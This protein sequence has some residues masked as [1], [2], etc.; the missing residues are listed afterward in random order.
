MKQM[1]WRFPPRGVFKF[2][3]MGVKISILILGRSLQSFF[4]KNDF[5]FKFL[6][7]LF[8]AIKISSDGNFMGLGTK[9]RPL[10]KRLMSLLLR[11]MEDKLTVMSRTSLLEYNKSSLK[12]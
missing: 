10:F 9:D 12:K 8:F 11:T 6:V 5:N 1:K 2:L 4:I 3:F 7:I